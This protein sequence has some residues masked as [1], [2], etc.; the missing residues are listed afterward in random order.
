M[1]S[2]PRLLALLTKLT[3]G[4]SFTSAELAEH[5][6]VTQRTIRRD[7]AALRELGYVIDAAPGADGGYRAGSRTVLPP[8]QLEAGEALATAVGLA[9]LRGV[10]LSSEM[11]D[12]AGQKLRERLPATVRT[13]LSDIASAVTV[14]PGHEPDVDH[15]HVVAIASAIAGTRLMT[16]TYSKLP[17]AADSDRRVEPVKMV[18]HGAYW[19]LYAWDCDRADWRIFRLDR[20]R[21]VHVTTFGFRPREHPD[22]EVAVHSA[23]A[24]AAY[25]YTVILQVKASIAEAESWFPSRMAIITGVEEGVRIEFG[26]ADLDWAAAIAAHIPTDFRVIGPP[27]MMDALDQLRRRVSRALGDTTIDRAEVAG[28]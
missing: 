11:A 12:S 19:Y 16:F 8:L 25:P 1:S 17:Y 6:A 2:D 10:G 13:T 27:E 4:R 28:K 18:V 5:F 23:V 20:M 9:L 21:G 7:I 22:A 3:S 14:L 24:S 15:T 26:A